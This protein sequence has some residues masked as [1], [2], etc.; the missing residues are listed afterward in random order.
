MG[1][2]VVYFYVVDA[3]DKLVGVLPTRRLLMGEPEQRLD[4]LMHKNVISLPQ[5]ATLLLACEF[6]VMHRLLA[7]PVVDPSGHM[8]GLVDVGLFTDEIFDLTERQSSDDVF[9]LIGVRLAQ[10]RTIAPWESFRQRFP[11]L[12]CNVAG[13]TICALL[14]GLYT[15][16]L[17]AALVVVL[18]LFIPVVLALAESVSMQSMTLTLQALHEQKCDF[19]F[20]LRA[21]GREFLTAL[22]LGT[23]TGA[24]VGLVALVWHQQPWVA[25]TIGSTILLSVATACVLGVLLPTAIRMLRGDPRIAAGPIVLATA[26]VVTLVLYFS[27]AGLLVRGMST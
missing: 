8:L 25:L 19:R 17:D 16:Q 24:L 12:L 7:F 14:S 11:W 4:A 9:Q 2:R 15:G 18:A 10:T 20:I 13:G 1:E 21:T 23:G 27:L 6:F 3:T 22:L 5:S 26:D